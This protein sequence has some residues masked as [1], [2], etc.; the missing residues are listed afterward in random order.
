MREGGI[1]P[2]SIEKAVMIVAGI[3]G[4]VIRAVHNDE[5]IIALAAPAKEIVRGALR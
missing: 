2:L 3:D 4:M 5:S 1:E